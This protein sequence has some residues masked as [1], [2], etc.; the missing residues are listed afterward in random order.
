MSVKPFSQSTDYP[1]L[2]NSYKFG[3]VLTDLS[4][5]VRVGEHHSYNMWGAYLHLSICLC[6]NLDTH[7]LSPLA[8]SQQA[9]LSEPERTGS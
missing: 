9:P 8:S 3:T 1:G 5:R 2:Y 4:D 6:N 7:K